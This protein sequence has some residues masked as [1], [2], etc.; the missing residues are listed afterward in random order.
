MMKPN[1]C[2]YCDKDISNL[3]V[4]VDFVQE[5]MPCPFCYRRIDIRITEELEK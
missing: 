3:W 5:L 1:I 2:P 4:K